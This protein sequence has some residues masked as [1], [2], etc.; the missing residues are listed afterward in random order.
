MR[1]NFKF[2]LERKGVRSYNEVIEA[3]GGDRWGMSVKPP[4]RKL[5]LAEI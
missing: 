2:I 1:H 3:G 4:L 5:H